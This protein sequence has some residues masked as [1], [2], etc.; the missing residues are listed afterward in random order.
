[1]E[2]LSISP[3][4]KYLDAV[5]VLKDV[6]NE[7]NTKDFF[8]T[9]NTLDQLLTKGIDKNNIPIVGRKG[10]LEDGVYSI[11]T[12]EGV[13]GVY[14]GK[15]EKGQPFNRITLNDTGQFYKSWQIKLQNMS[16]IISADDVKEGVKITS[17]IKNGTDILGLNEEN[18]KKFEEY[19]YNL[20]LQRIMSIIFD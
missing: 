15:R 8:I 16:Y 4:L 11:N 18:T 20:V 17:L 2:I 12:I 7:Q 6:L 5:N 14:K 3:K 10:Y 1:M 19:L 13:Q 9:L